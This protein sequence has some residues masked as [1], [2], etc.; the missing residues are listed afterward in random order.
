M[1]SLNANSQ[2][3]SLFVQ[4]PHRSRSLSR[5]ARRLTPE[6]AAR[7]GGSARSGAG[8]QTSEPRPTLLPGERDG[9]NGPEPTRYGDW[10]KNGIASDF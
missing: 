7:A 5:S 2:W 6:A 3:V 8:W 1:V 9:R 10:E 4:G